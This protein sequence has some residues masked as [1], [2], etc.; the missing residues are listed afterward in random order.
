MRTVQHSTHQRMPRWRAA[1][2]AALMLVT[3]GVV[4][5]VAATPAQAVCIGRNSNL[6]IELERPTDGA[7]LARETWRYTTTCD[8]LGDYYGR[9]QDSI[10]DGSCAYALFFEPNPGQNQ[11]T[12]GVACT[13]GGWANYRYNDRFSPGSDA[14]FDLRTDDWELPVWIHARGF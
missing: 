11:V 9:V 4:V 13:T 8:V 6:S 1:L 7:I 3:S 12:A 14:W 2:A 5:A 10:T